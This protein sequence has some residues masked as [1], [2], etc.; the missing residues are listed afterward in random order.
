MFV[1]WLIEYGIQIIHKGGH[2]GTEQMNE[3]GEKEGSHAAPFSSIDCEME[4]VSREKTSLLTSVVDGNLRGR[5][6]GESGSDGSP[7]GSHSSQVRTSVLFA[8]K[9]LNRRNVVHLMI[10]SGDDGCHGGFL[11][12]E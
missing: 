6:R 7:V 2:K 10:D 11:F 3:E 1:I 4:V 12:L 8:R 5:K 9:S